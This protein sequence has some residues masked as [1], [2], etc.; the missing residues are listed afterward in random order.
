MRRMSSLLLLAVLL[1]TASAKSAVVVPGTLYGLV[2]DNVAG[3]ET[4]VTV[5]PLTGAVTP[6]GPGV[7]DCCTIGGFPVSVLNPDT[8]VMY[9]AGNL[10]SD[11][12]GSA[13]RLLGFDVLTGALVSSPFLPAGYLFNLFKIDLGS[14]TIYGLVF[15]LGPGLEQL[16]T[17]DPATAAFSPVGGPIAD[18]CTLGGFP[19]SALDPD[20]GILY[21]AGNLLSD[22]GG[23][24]PRLLGFDTATGSLVA[25]GTLPGG[26][27][28]NM[29][30]LDHGTGT[31]FG[32]VFDLG[33]GLEQVV[34]VDPVTAAFT[35]VGGPVA[36]C[37][38]IGGFP[39][40]A[41]DPD[42]GIFYIA[43]NLLSDPPA[44][45][46]RL[47]GFDTVTGLLVTSPTLAT[48]FNYNRIELAVVLPVNQPPVAVCQDVTVPTDP[49]ACEADA[50]VDGG[51]FDPDG[52]PITF[53]QD[54]P[55]PYPLGDTLVTLTVEDDSGETD[56]CQATVTVV[57]EEPPVV[58][59]QS[60]PTIVPPDAP[61]AFT[62]TATDNCGPASVEVVSFDCWA[63]KGPG[64]RIDK[65]ASCVVEI[66]GAT[67][68][69]LDSG[70][71]GTHIGWTV[72]ATD[73]SGN[74]QG[75]DCE[76]TVVNPG[77]P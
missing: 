55:G 64:K 33:P 76:V 62:A 68:T 1:P 60:P 7:P 40:T 8:G 32:L 13:K 29:I 53:T 4:V 56:S 50:S 54:P 74:S 23:S 27:L 21:I 69:V 61:I 3:M 11:P 19:V 72:E 36:D 2:F 10:L 52:D 48:G 24:S 37:C 41:L 5:D 67:V 42:T 44:T 16:V 77:G 30:N 65:R 63:I 12:G 70:G 75:A 47:L 28:Y 49:G 25:S 35:P 15:D 43:G 20:T 22:P 14:G 59:C 17:V 71:V 46:R 26:F 58:S 18:C 38:T 34:T 9:V 51:S 66:A 57:D 6:V 31:L 45:D 73:P 39:V